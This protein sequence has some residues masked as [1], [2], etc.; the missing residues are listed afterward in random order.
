MVGA[1][2]L[3]GLIGVV[4]CGPDNEGDAAKTAAQNKDP[5]AKEEAAPKFARSQKE[6]FENMPKATDQMAKGQGLQPK[7]TD[8]TPNK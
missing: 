5:N 7:G 8:T 6:A 3:L 4:G 2:V 1:F